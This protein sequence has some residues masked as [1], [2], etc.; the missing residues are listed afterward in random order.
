MFLQPRHV[1][2][3]NLA[4]RGQPTIEGGEKG[5]FVLDVVADMKSVSGTV[6]T[7]GVKRFQ[8]SFPKTHHRADELLKLP[9]GEE[10][11]ARGRN[12]VSS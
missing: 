2:H 11:S 1:L 9:W 7:S 5:R 10:G 12:S 4:D 3:Q 8:D 6:R